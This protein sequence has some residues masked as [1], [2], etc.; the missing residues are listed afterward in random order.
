MINLRISHKLSIS[1]LIVVVVMG[2]IGFIDIRSLNKVDNYSNDI[3]NNNFQSIYMMTDMRNNLSQIRADVL[4]LLY[5]R[6]DAEQ[7]KALEK[8]IK[9]NDDLIN[10]YI[11]KYDK[12]P[13]NADEKKE[14]PI[15]KQNLEQYIN[16]RTQLINYIDSG[17]YN[18]AVAFLPQVTSVREKLNNSL[19]KIIQSNLTDGDIAYNNSVLVYDKARFMM[20]MFMGI[21][22][23]VSIILGFVLNNNI[24]IPLI[25]AVTQLK[26]ISKGDLTQVTP[27]KYL[28]RKDEIGNM[29]KS[30]DEMKNDLT[31]LIKDI[32][33]NS[34]NLSVLSEE[35][36]SSVEE[37]SDTLETINSSTSEI[38][39]GVQN[40][41]SSA[42]E[43]TASVEEVNASI[44]QLSERA[45]QGSNNACNIKERALNVQEEGKKSLNNI[46]KMYKEKQKAI[47]NA[48]E[49]GKVVDE[50]KIMADIIA[51][52]ASQTNLLALN[53]AIEA[54]RAGEQG[55]GFAVVAEEV[56][57]LAEQSTQS[58]NNIHNIIK[59]VKHAFNNLSNYSS[60]ILKFMDNDI[61]P[62]F[63]SFVEMGSQYYED[64]DFLS[65]MSEELSFMTEEINATIEQI[66]EAVQTMVSTSQK[67]AENTNEIEKN[68]SDSS[69][70][71][72]QMAKSSQDQAKLAQ[73]LNEMVMR[74]K[75]N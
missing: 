15:F 60:N 72:E 56:R 11:S 23:I 58:V 39:V 73:K 2:V 18:D 28:K 4:K 47:L 24:A 34:Q 27:K 31:S 74:F 48:I 30:I 12:L 36:S 54:A 66:S 51:N 13:M 1:F 62:Q 5:E 75:I 20:I 63:H 33:E 43:I 71:V 21:G 41:S 32:M 50:I 42:E 6:N 7:N 68:I 65:K 8:D 59:T 57:K 46:Q 52:I 19:E 22:V 25:F 16:L 40:T 38:S 49:E 69:Q 9:S 17:K 44:S 64:A 61:N 35:V 55:K 26:V 70:G 29:E 3:Y 37:I 53:A 14:W 45:I 67:A 10:K